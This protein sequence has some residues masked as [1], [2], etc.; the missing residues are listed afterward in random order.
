MSN[1]LKNLTVLLID[2]NGNITQ[3]LQEY[4]RKRGFQVVCAS[5]LADGL[6]LYRDNSCDIVLMRDFLSDG[7]ACHALQDLTLKAY[8]PII[9]I[10]SSAGNPEQAEFALK[11]GAWD[12]VVNPQPE[13][14]LPDLLKRAIRYQVSRNDNLAES[15]IKDDFVEHGIIGNSSAI[16]NCITLAAKISNSDAN[17]LLTGESGTGKELFARAIHNFSKRATRQL[18]VVDC[19]ALPSSLVESILFGHSKGSFTGADKSHQ[20]L[21]KQ[22]D[23]GTLFLDEIGETPMGIQK[24]LLRVIQERKY[25]PVGSNVEIKSDFR[26]ISATNRNVQRMVSKGK[27]REDLYF[28]LRTFQMELPPLRNRIVDL[29]QLTYHFRNTY[30]KRNKI[31]K[32]KI[33][34]EYLS[35]LAQY[36]WPGNVRE[37]VHTIERS[38]AVAQDSKILYSTHL[39]TTIR[40]EVI[41]KKLERAGQRAAS[42][43]EKSLFGYEQFDADNMP[44]LGKARDRAYETEEKRYMENLIARFGKD[45]KKCCEISGI[46]RS[47]FYDLLKKHE[48][49]R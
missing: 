33:S 30:S 35:S 38:M 37:L 6:Q 8:S 21:V 23:G 49:S 32:K 43:Q 2:G 11:H 16:N 3:T 17:V 31:E 14:I 7:N 24:K 1:T 22:A 18:V 28:R 12:Y 25:R 10:Y 20:G 39:P 15:T 45:V 34:A 41:R 5:T 4:S 47:R 36:D 26:L 42:C 19:A 40:I 27:F 13:V 29:T 44:S 46:S 9:I 48:I